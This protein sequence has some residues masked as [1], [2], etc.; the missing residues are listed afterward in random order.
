MTCR[1]RRDSELVMRRA[2]RRAA[3][4]L[5]FAMTSTALAAGLF[6]TLPSASQAADRHPD[7]RLAAVSRVPGSLAGAATARLI[8]VEARSRGLGISMAGVGYA[9][10]ARLDTPARTA[11]I[12]GVVDD[13]A[14]APV[15]R[16]RRAPPG[17][18]G[19]PETGCPARRPDPP[20]RL[21]PRP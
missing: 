18:S 17:P 15:A 3:R 14:G 4:S 21:L 19:R 2:S 7:L 16:P 13:V 5:A 12:A 10:A 20:S 1:N 6:G 9:G 11:V 8:A